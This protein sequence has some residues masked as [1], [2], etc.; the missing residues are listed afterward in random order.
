MSTSTYGIVA[1]NWENKAFEVVEKVREALKSFKHKRGVPFKGELSSDLCA[2]FR[3]PSSRGII[4]DFKDGEDNRMLWIHFDC[5]SDQKNVYNGKK[6]IF[7]LN[8]WGNSEKIIRTVLN[9]F[10]GKERYFILND[11]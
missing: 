10:K 5:H 1:G 11:C 6:L 4:V 2:N 8:L 9:Q 3:I 7:S